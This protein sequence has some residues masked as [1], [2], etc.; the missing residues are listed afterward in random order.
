MPSIDALLNALAERTIAREIGTTH[1]E[2]RIRYPLHSNT[3][4]TFDDFA[5]IIG[6]Y[7]NQH[8]TQCVSRGGSLSG[9][10]ATSAAKK[11]IESAYRRR[12]GTI[13]TAFN[14]AHDGTNGGLRVVL[15]VLA[16]GLKAEAVENYIRDAFDRNVTPNSWEKKVEIIRQ[17]IARCGLDMS[18]SIHADQPERY[19]QNYEE[20]IRSYVIVLQ[21]TSSVFR[22]L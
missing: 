15:D 18:S 9:S 4:G 8:F 17:F 13:M 21:R 19:A 11:I 2:A 10:D 7:Y 14:D 6:D 1:D 20:L 3:V 5:D 22:R 16:D 12:G